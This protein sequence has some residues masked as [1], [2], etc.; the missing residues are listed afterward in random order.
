VVELDLPGSTRPNSLICAFGGWNDGGQA[1]TTAL[2]FLRESYGARKVGSIDPE[3]YYDFQVARP[4]VHLVDGTTREIRWAEND[5]FSAR[6]DQMDLLLFQGLEPNLKW[7]SFCQEIIG[8]AKAVGI[9]QLITL[10]AFLADVPHT[11]IPSV[12]GSSSDSEIARRMG[13]VR[14]QYEGPTGIVG[15]LQSAAAGAGLVSVSF[16]TGTPHY[17]AGESSPRA[18][19]VLVAK[20]AELLGISPDVS[21]LERAAIAWEARIGEAISSNEELS[22]YVSKLE[23]LYPE[24]SA[25]MQIPN[26]DDLDAELQEFLRRASEDK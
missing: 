16:W 20:A 18:A 9:T 7:R 13:M 12:V 15:V 17:L 10:G 3:E 23:E 8:A 24:R 6:V 26:S 19:H 4:M 21:S 14:S 25:E 2:G 22:A 5:F 11:R 1:A